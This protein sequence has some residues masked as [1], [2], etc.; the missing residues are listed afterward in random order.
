[1]NKSDLITAVAEKAGA[2]KKDTEKVIGALFSELTAALANG[3]TVQIAG[4]G[5]F[6]VRDRAGRVA[7]NPATGVVVSVP[8]AKVPAFKAG[9]T[10]K[11]AVR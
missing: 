4:F 2:T 11:D 9:K 3:D 5:S 8:A 1:M 7:R 6:S 10:L